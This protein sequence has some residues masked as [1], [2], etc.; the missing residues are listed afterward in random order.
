[1]KTAGLILDVYDDLQGIVLRKKLAGGAL[2]TKL[3]S[4]DLL[5]APDL[6][7]LPD[8]MFGL[9]AANGEETLRKYAMHDEAHLATSIIYFL[10]CGHILPKTAQATTAKNLL[11][12]CAWYDLDPP[13]PLVKKAVLGALMTTAAMG[14]TA[15]DGMEKKRKDM[16]QFQRVQSGALE[17]PDVTKQA[18]LN[19][20]SVMPMAGTLSGPGSEKTIK[21]ALNTAARTKQKVS[22]LDDF[23]DHFDGSREWEPGADITGLGAPAK[24]V[25][26]YNKHFALRDERKYPIDTYSQ[27]KEASAYFD[28]YW[29]SFSEGTRR[30]YA[31]AVYQR[32]QA[33]GVKLA[34]RV[35]DYAGDG[36]GPH[37]DLELLSRANSFEGIEGVDTYTELRS[38]VASYTP[39]EM[40]AALVEADT[41]MGVSGAYNKAVVGF[42][43]PYAAVYGSAK[44]A[45]E[46]TAISSRSDATEKNTENFSWNH[47]SD[48]VNDDM[49]RSYASRGKNVFCSAFEEDMWPDF[50]KDPVGFFT[51][52]PDPQ[53]HALARLASDDAGQSAR[54]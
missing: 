11:N 1:M 26:E 35:L 3:A 25:A 38:K 32:A 2:P 8:R 31:D 4:A 16:A 49:L 30:Q 13:E 5:E 36:F 18:D 29:G 24:K 14:M 19:G 12:A 33:V 42:R 37:I 20:S 46:G 21:P 9:V 50:Q 45:A 10:E 48:Y 27:V 52:L 22:G 53:K 15:R 39:E 43:D 7:R 6:A 34:G 51:A 40:V 23:L 17:T 44:F 41:A 47:G 28:E 54:S